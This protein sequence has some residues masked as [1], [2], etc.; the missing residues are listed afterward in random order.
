M[1]AAPLAVRRTDFI[2]VLRLVLIPEEHSAD[3]KGEQIKYFQPHTHRGK[4][5][6]AAMYLR[7]GVVIGRSFGSTCVIVVPRP[8]P[9]PLLAA[10]RRCR[11]RRITLGR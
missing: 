4:V 3:E 11:S 6:H 1:P 8:V 9:R 2:A 10:T 7:R 5:T